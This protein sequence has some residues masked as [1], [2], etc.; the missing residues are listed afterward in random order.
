ME[1]RQDKAREA[2]MSIVVHSNPA[3]VFAQNR[4]I[5]YSEMLND[6]YEVLSTGAR[7][8]KSADDPT[9]AAVSTHLDHRIR[10]QGI[11]KRNAH[12]AISLLQTT[13]GG[14]KQVVEMLH[15]M[16]EL[17][18][19]ASTESLTPSNRAA[20]NLEFQGLVLEIDRI[21]QTTEFQGQQML[22]SSLQLT[23]QVGM[24]NLANDRITLTTSGGLRASS[25]GLEF[26]RID[27]VAAA[28]QTLGQLS[29][30]MASVL[31][32]SALF[33]ATMNRLERS[34]FSL[35]SDIEASSSAEGRIMDADFAEATSMLSRLRVLMESTSAV[36][37]QANSIPELAINLVR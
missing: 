1:G 14:V 12:A 9:A 31:D 27:T 18:T 37:G 25:L 11:A 3:S 15:R 20:A 13:E 33:G 10:A 8:N 23:F 16:R 5:R 29:A 24:D 21:A 30:A 34:I 2:P 19:R 17:A 6:N 28:H 26:E 22:N 7:V 36:I 35:E 4:L 32:K